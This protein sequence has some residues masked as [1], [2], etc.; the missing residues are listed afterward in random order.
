MLVG[1]TNSRT[2]CYLGDQN[3]AGHVVVVKD[4]VDGYWLVIDPAVG[5]VKW[6]HREMA[7]RFTGE[8]LYLEDQQH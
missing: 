5:L 4:Y 6:S 1:A 3:A 8:A 7:T 2:W